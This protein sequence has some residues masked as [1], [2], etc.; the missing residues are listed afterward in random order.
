MDK[1]FTDVDSSIL[2]RC[3]QKYYDKALAKYN[4]GY[5]HLLFL[6]KIYENE[7]LTMNELAS[8][9]SFDKGTITKSLKVLEQFGYVDIINNQFD[10][11]S[12]C[13]YT[14]DKANKIIPE[15]YI[16]RQQ[17]QEYL[18]KDISSFDFAIFEEVMGKVID[19]AREYD[20]FKQVSDVKIYGLQKLTLLDYPGKM[21]C[22]I[23]TGGCNFRCPYCHNRSLVF[24]NEQDGEFDKDDLFDYLNQRRNIL[25]GVCI[26][27]GEPLLQDGLSDF[28][29]EIKDYG[30]LVKL[31]T[32]GSNPDK[33]KELLDLGLV[34][35]IAMDIKNTKDKYALSIGLNDFNIEDIEKSVEL[36]KSSSIDYE[37]RMTV[38]KEYHKDL[39]V[40]ALGNWLR[41]C[42]QFFLQNFEDNGSCIKQGLHSLDN[43]TI[44]DI[45]NKLEKY[46]DK[47]YVRG[48][49]E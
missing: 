7:G 25:D 37:F 14:S 35:Y 31:D 11:R 43:D 15:L 8:F 22:T 3:S 4:L 40:D 29:K 45:K 48:V 10:K 16:L 6:L 49:K 39:D 27:G 36:L 33:L 26:S 21:A 23:F 38:V 32:N 9:G 17:W 42:K 47:V 30:L 20:S 18:F 34:D 19:R 44:F 1:N 24:L 46:I 13:L 2:Y 12:R 41:G 28:I 5:T